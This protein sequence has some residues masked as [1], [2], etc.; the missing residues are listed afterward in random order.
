MPRK[1]RKP[2]QEYIDQQAAEAAPTPAAPPP[3]VPP[4]G[5]YFHMTPREAP[6]DTS[7]DVASF[8]TP[9]NSPAPEPAAPEPSAA[10]KRRPN[11]R[12]AQ[13]DSVGIAVEVEVEPRKPWLQPQTLILFRDDA[14]PNAEEKAKLSDAGFTYQ[15]GAQGWGMPKSAASLVL[16]KRL[17]S[18][19]AK[20][21]GDEGVSL[22]V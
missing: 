13:I 11:A 3:D 15:A 17:A 2:V 21:R 5:V 22:Y 4:A 19:L 7:F 6:A 1:S 9:A 10:P 20:G 18:D 8:D 12:Y 14:K 16:A